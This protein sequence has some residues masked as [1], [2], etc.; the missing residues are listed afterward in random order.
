MTKGVVATHKRRVRYSGTHPQ[1][2][3]DKY[4]ELEPK[5]HAGEVE[6]VMQRGQTPAGTQ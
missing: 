5:S 2:F 3:E 6:K 4:K 1:R